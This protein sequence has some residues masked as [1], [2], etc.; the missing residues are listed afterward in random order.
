MGSRKR[1]DNGNTLRVEPRRSKENSNR[2]TEVQKST[3][4]VRRI[5]PEESTQVEKQ[6]ASE[7]ERSSRNLKRHAGV[8]KVDAITLE[9]S[10]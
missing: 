2:A 3:K 5:H 4:H 9:Q 10:K 1:R 7:I 6:G 8:Y